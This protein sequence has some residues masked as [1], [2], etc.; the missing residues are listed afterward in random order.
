MREFCNQ[1]FRNVRF[2]SF[3]HVELDLVFRIG[4]QVGIAEAKTEK[5]PKKDSID[6]INSPT[7]REFLGT[8]TKKFLFLSNE[9]GSGNK[10]LADAYKISVVE[11]KENLT[12]GELSADDFELLKERVTKILGS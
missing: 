2:R 6:Q 3:S 9:F 8:Y 4:N 7:H 11:L 10:A 5:E 12:G 1:V